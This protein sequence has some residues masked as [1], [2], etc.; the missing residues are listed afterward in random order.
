MSTPAA[1]Q[2]QKQV[3]FEIESGRKT[4]AMIVTLIGVEGVGKS[5]FAKDAG[6]VF[7]DV[8]HGTNDLVVDRIKEPEEGWSW[9]AVLSRLQQLAAGQHKHPAV[10]I[11]TL[12]ALESLIWKHI[13]A[14][15]QK[16]NIEE[17]GYG[18]GYVAALDQWKIFVAAIEQLKTKAS[19]NVFLLAHT[20]VK[21][22][23]NPEGEDFDRYQPA[24]HVKAGGLLKGRSDVVLFANF[25]QFAKKKNER[26]KMEKAKGIA[27]GRRVI[28]TTRSAAYDAKNRLDLPPVLPLSYADFAAAMRGA[29]AATPADLRKLIEEKAAL[30]K[31]K[32]GAAGE[33]AAAD[34]AGAVKRAGEDVQKL[35]QLN[36]W[37]AAKLEELAAAAQ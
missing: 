17:Y 36:N 16:D 31:A 13:C 21:N 11:D 5:T 20:E 25:E 18:K 30:M 27:T 15:D 6:A 23:K 35:R 14:R 1:V 10:A 4:S 24:L 37:C 9:P 29:A 32:P 3:P 22:F 26:D 19:M 12:D 34:V 33:A 8:E 2:S 7:I 28:Y